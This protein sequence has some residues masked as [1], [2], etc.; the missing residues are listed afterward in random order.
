[1]GRLPTTSRRRTQKIRVRPSLPYR[2]RMKAWG[3]GHESVAAAVDARPLEAT[4][5]Q[6]AQH[7]WIECDD[8]QALVVAQLYFS[9]HP[10]LYLSFSCLSCLYCLTRPSFFAQLVSIHVTQETPQHCRRRRR[11][12]IP[13]I[14]PKRNRENKV[15]YTR[16]CRPFYTGK[17]RH[18]FWGWKEKRKK[19]KKTV[20]IASKYGKGESY[21]GRRNV[22]DVAE[23]EDG[24]QCRPETH[25]Q[26]SSAIPISAAA[27][28]AAMG[29]IREWRRRARLRT[30]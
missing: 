16:S 24:Y 11:R 26:G 10:R 27:A 29:S 3:G 6:P 17:W 2:R 15:K 13:K 21:M 20:C 9:R 18:T 23:R 8:N 4:R 25:G 30:K 12:R 1:M 28:A 14:K 7:W 5:R 19:K 22:I